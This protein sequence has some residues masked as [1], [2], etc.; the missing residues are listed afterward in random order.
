[1]SWSQTAAAR[2]LK[3]RQPTISKM[4]NGNIDQL[5]IEFLIKLMVQA[6]LPAGITGER[7]SPGRSMARRRAGHPSAAAM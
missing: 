3:V 2:A 4:V 6:G 1:M 5:S 7:A